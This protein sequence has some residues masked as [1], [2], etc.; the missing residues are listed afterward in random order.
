LVAD[1]HTLDRQLVLITN[2][3]LVSLPIVQ[4]VYNDWRLRGRIE[5]GGR[6]DQEQGLDV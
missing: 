2:I 6:F 4:S 5:Q 3:P 1:D